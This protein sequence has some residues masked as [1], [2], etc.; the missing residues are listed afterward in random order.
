M[1]GAKAVSSAVPGG[2]VWNGVHSGPGAVVSA[3]ATPGRPYARTRQ[4]HATL[5]GAPTPVLHKNGA[6]GRLV[7]CLSLT[8]WLYQVPFCFQDVLCPLADLHAVCNPQ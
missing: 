4:A 7:M 2:W 6:A 1:W 8:R 5:P 3:V